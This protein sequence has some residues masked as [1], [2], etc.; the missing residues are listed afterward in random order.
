MKLVF[1]YNADSGFLNSLLDIGHKI[2]K[3]E[4]YT[5]NLCSLTFGNFAENAK[6]K[7]FREGSSHEM[8]FLHRDEFEAK[9]GLKLPCPVILK[10]SG[11]GKLEVLIAAERLESFKSLDEL[12]EAVQA[13]A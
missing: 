1:V 4:T 5:C 3:P 8:E 9:Y 12:I 13:L 11:G 7:A 6:W 2:I 10:E